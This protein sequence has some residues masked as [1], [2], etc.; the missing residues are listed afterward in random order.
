VNRE[1]VK[2]LVSKGLSRA[3]RLVVILYYYE[4]LSMK[5]IGRALDLSEAR[6]SQIHSSVLLRL[7]ATLT[8]DE[9]RL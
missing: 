6:V 3:E 1:A 8:A 2:E 9:L 4:S 5:E 7:R